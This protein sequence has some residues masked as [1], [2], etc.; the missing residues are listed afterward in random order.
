MLINLNSIEW[1]SDGSGFIN[2]EYYLN[3]GQWLS[4]L[5]PDCMGLHPSMLDVGSGG[6]I[7]GYWIDYLCG[8]R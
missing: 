1:I 5:S 6:E 7:R 3:I 8:V 2:T 4:V